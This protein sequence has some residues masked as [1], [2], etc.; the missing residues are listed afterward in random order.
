MNKLER[1]E[2]NTTFYNLFQPYLRELIPAFKFKGKW[3]SDF[4]KNDNPIVVEL[5]CGKGEYTV[6]LGKKYPDRNF[7]GIDQKG[8][9]LWRGCKTSIDDAMTNVAFIRMQMELIE[10]CFAK[11][12]ISEIWITFPE[13]QPQNGKAKKRFTS[14]QFNTRF[15]NILKRDGIINLKT[16]NSAFYDYT[17]EVISGGNHDL[18][19]STD[20]LY[21]THPELE[22]ASIQTFYEEMWLKQGLTIKFLQYKLNADMFTD[23]DNISTFVTNRQY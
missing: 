17:L 1:F 21:A 12:E 22:V 20:D 11:E 15:S 4:F 6:G 14:P 16:D 18:L 23:G 5:G 2:E 9:R 19:F 7:I 10:Y 8:A 3:N 13:P